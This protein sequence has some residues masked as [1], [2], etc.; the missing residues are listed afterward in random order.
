MRFTHPLYLAALLAMT[1]PALANDAPGLTGGGAGAAAADHGQAQ[2]GGYAAAQAAAH[3]IVTQWTHA[4]PVAPADAGLRSTQ[5]RQCAASSGPAPA[6]ADCRLI[7]TDL[8]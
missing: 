8:P 2:R 7:I 1:P 3:I 4:A 5:A 6:S